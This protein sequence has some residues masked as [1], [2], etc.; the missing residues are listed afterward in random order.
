MY[1]FIHIPKTGGS[2]LRHM[3][4]QSFGGRH[5]DI[6]VPSRQRTAQVQVSDVDMRRARRVYPRL[7]GICGHRVNCF[8]GLEKTEPMIRFFTFVR[9]PVARFIS[10]FHHHQRLK[11]T[12]VTREDFLEFCA[13]PHQR[14]VQCRWLGGTDAAERS[15]EMLRLHI[16]FVGLTGDFDASVLLFNRWLN[17]P[18]FRMAHAPRNI[19]PNRPAFDM[20]GDEELMAAAREANAED[21]IV[22][23]KIVDEIYPAQIASYGPGLETDL[24]KLRQDNQSYRDEGESTWARFKRNVLYKPLLHL[25]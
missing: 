6:K 23:R 8:S 16:G 21:L 9:E 25:G 10:H 1:A 20:V 15:M 24:Q 22:Y 11:P 3:L 5:L 13:D 18:D 2:T 4:R 7:E 19:Q 17:H 12:G 14:N